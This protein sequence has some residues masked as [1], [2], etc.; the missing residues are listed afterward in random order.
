MLYVTGGLADGFLI[1]LLDEDD[2]Y[3]RGWAIRLLCENQ[4]VPQKAIARFVELAKSGSSPYVRLQLAS[5]LQRLDPKQ[6]WPI[7]EA[8]VTNQQDITDANLPLMIWYGVEPLV[9]DDLGRFIH[10]A[11]K[12]KFPLI[13][14]HIARRVLANPNE[15]QG[16]DL[17]VQLLGQLDGNQS[18]QDLLSG[19]LTGLEGSRTVKMPK[20][21][22][23]VYAKLHGHDEE[24]TRQD[25][26]RLA[27][28]FDDPVAYATLRKI[29]ENPRESPANR[30]GAIQALVRKK[31]DDL[32]DL[33][34]KLIREPATQDV[35]L[36]GLAEYTHPK[37]GGTILAIYPSFNETARQNALLTLASRREWAMALLDRVEAKT[38]SASELTAYTARQL[39]NLDDPQ[40][41]ARLK[42][43][44]GNVR[45]TPAEKAQLI[46]KFKNRLTP[47][48]LTQADRQAGRA[49]S[50][51]LRELPQAVRRRRE[52]R[53]RY[54]RRP[55]DEFGLSAANLDRPERRRGQRLSDGKNR[56]DQR[57]DDYRLG[58]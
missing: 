24:K 33:L 12:A 37:I 27:L 39:E 2:E 7:A 52:N 54:Y 11:A 35:A 18:L 51:D 3:L 25:A 13:R 58:H 34:L 16:L 4:R 43:L 23:D 9:I 56:H 46:A 41:T 26:L 47:E 28:K 31:P 5:A 49:L 29:A 20:S 10:L 8:L 32:P 19:M 55:A 1:D 53:S 45:P 50:K 15:A 17:L 40:V 57:A 48:T 14:R 38:I 36:R 44:W 21:W 6:R 30:T 42:S 22:P